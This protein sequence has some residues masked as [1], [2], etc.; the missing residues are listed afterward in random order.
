MKQEKSGNQSILQQVLAVIG[1]RQYLVIS[2]I[3]SMIEGITFA[4]IAYTGGR[5]FDKIV[6]KDLPGMKVELL[7][8]TLSAAAWTISIFFKNSLVG[9]YIERG[10][11]VLR[12]KT[13][14]ALEKTRLLQLSA[15]HSGELSSR[16]F[17]DLNS[18][19]QGIEPVFFYGVSFLFTNILQTAALFLINWQ[20]TLIVLAIAPVMMWLQWIAS[21][22]IKKL[23]QKN[24]N[25]VGNISSITNDSFGAMETIKSLGL[26]GEMIT[27]FDTAQQAQVAAATQESLVSAL[28]GPIGTISWLFPRIAVVVIGGW[29]VSQG[30]LTIGEL[31]VFV[32]LSSTTLSFIRSSSR[33]MANIRQL[34]VAC[35]RVIAL[36]NLPKEQTGG[37]TSFPQQEAPVIAFTDVCFAYN[38]AETQEKN[39]IQKVSFSLMPGNMLALVGESGCGKSTVLKLASTLYTPGSGR[40]AF[41]GRDLQ[42]WDLDALRDHIAYVTQETFLFPG[43][44]YDNLSL[45]RSNCTRD[46]A[47][48]V[49]E[50]VGLLPFVRALPHGLDSNVGEKG[51]YLSGGQR[52]RISIARALLSG[53]K[54]LLLD[55]ATSALDAENEQAVLQTLTNLDSAPA[56]LMVSHRL[57]AVAEADNMIVMDSGTVVQ[58]GAPGDLA[59]REGPYRNMLAMQELEVAQ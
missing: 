23:R 28:L 24:L 44:L 48:A 59:A 13:V 16:V 18:L 56:I 46:E 27:R 1:N 43:S 31:L 9:A 41:W 38:Q 29:F 49:L 39:T 21:K 19:I 4:L 37:Q 34:G 3:L 53:A 10:V 57:S 52:Q 8:V 36:W 33:I 14:Q 25:A 6:A 42:D 22:P 11:K 12:Q 40:I 35:E 58:Q 2:I 30:H 47:M 15:I 50:K 54:L 5:M 7:F 26:E 17:N 55:E 20:L 45:L 32:T 51:A